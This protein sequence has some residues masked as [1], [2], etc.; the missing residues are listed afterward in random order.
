MMYY[1]IR[2]K[3]APKEFIF[4]T[5]RH[6]VLARDVIQTIRNNFKIF[7]D[8]LRVYDENGKRLQEMDKVHNGRTFII[9]RVPSSQQGAI[10]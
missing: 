3:A 9:K 8:D 5:L 1:R 4:E 2:F 10:T 7:Q 6:F